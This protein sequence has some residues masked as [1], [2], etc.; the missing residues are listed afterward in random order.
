MFATYEKIYNSNMSLSEFLYISYKKMY[1]K[2]DK[3]KKLTELLN[4]NKAVYIINKADD[5]L[6][7]YHHISGVS[8]SGIIPYFTNSEIIFENDNNI[9]TKTTILSI[10]YRFVDEVLRAI[11]LLT[12]SLN[13]DD[14]LFNE[15]NDLFNTMCILLTSCI[16]KNRT[17]E[18]IL[19]LKIIDKITERG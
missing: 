9:Y 11:M 8:N 10:R 5:F 12:E 7:Q 19:L 3:I 14:K 2:I 6:S 16:Q 13:Q 17:E 15:L 18:C 1:I 4:Q